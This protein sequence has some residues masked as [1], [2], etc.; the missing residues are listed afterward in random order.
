LEGEWLLDVLGALVG[1]PRYYSNLLDVLR[2]STGTAGR[3]RKPRSVVS[4]SMLSRT[5]RVMEYRGLVEGTEGRD[6]P[7]PAVYWLT[8]PGVELA[9]LLE[10]LA[11][12][13]ERHRELLERDLPIG[14]LL[15]RI[16]RVRPERARGGRVPRPRVPESG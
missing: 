12:W 5:L 2:T 14:K 7:Y 8:E 13:A 15:A 9:G 4:D 16:R 1:G 6:F 3:G 10:P 11:D